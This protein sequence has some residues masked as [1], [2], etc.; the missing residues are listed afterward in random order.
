MVPRAA[1]RPTPARRPSTGSI[2]AGTAGDRRHLPRPGDG[3]AGR[4]PPEVGRPAR[5]SRARWQPRSAGH[6]IRAGAHPVSLYDQLGPEF[7]A[8]AEALSSA[9]TGSTPPALGY[10]RIGATLLPAVLAAWAS[11]RP[12][13]RAIPAG[14]ADP[15]LGR[16]RP[17]SARP[18][19]PA[20]GAPPAQSDARRRI[21]RSARPEHS[22]AAVAV[23]AP[24]ATSSARSW[25]RTRPRRHPR[26]DRPGPA[27]PVRAGHHRGRSVI[28]QVLGK[29]GRQPGARLRRPGGRPPGAP[30]RGCRSRSQVRRLRCL[31]EDQA[32]GVLRASRSRIDAGSP[33]HAARRRQW[34]LRW[35]RT[36][37]AGYGRTR[38]P[39]NR[40]MPMTLHHSEETHQLL[41]DRVPRR[42]ASR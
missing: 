26:P 12:R 36:R 1:G 38:T 19:T 4:P 13:L 21:S 27:V 10:R 40:R 11:S 5:R 17:W 16:R 22:R 29:V 30:G 39:P 6:A 3:P 25:P 8:N 20:G 37:P 31:A 32:V 23:G 28:G 15:G 33:R 2:D 34:G 9:P 24:S 18:G 14:P 7:E 41:V 42:P 35:H